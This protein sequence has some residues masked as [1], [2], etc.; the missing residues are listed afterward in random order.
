MTEC[1]VMTINEGDNTV[2]L[3]R[4]SVDADKPA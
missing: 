3:T 1:K 4:T 2:M